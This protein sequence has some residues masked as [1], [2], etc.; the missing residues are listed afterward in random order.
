MDMDNIH[1]RGNLIIEFPGWVQHEDISERTCRA[2]RDE[3][4]HL[5]PHPDKFLAFGPDVTF[6]SSVGSG[7]NPGIVH[8]E[9]MHK[10][11][12]IGRKRIV[13]LYRDLAPEGLSLSFLDKKNPR[14][15]ERMRGPFR[16]HEGGVI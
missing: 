6:R 15:P 2:C 13:E 14:I 1:G 4:G 8:D 11:K 3:I 9:D 10:R 12:V 7:G 16:R 5:V